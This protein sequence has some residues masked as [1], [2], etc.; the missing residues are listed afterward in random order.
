[1]SLLKWTESAT[2]DQAPNIRVVFLDALRGF[3]LLGIY[4][5]NIRVFAE[6]ANT[7]Y[8]LH[9]GIQPFLSD[10]LSSRFT[11]DIIEGTMRGLF[12]LLFGA[13]AMVFLNEARLASQ[14]LDIVDRYY[15]RALLLI[16]FGL[17]HAYLLLWPYDVL[18]IYGVISML[19]FP[20]RKISPPVL[21]VIGLL[22]LVIGD[23]D[24]SEKIEHLTGAG[25][26][27]TQSLKGIIE[28]TNKELMLSEDTYLQE[29]DIPEQSI[30][31][32]VE[33]SELPGYLTL[34]QRNI[35]NV[36]SQQ[37]SELY[38]D[39][40]FDVGGMMIIGIALFKLGIL[41][42]DRS[43]KFY[44]FMMIIC[45][46]L[47]FLA[48]DTSIYSHIYSFMNLG[49][50][51]NKSLAGYN[52]GRMI[53]T[54]GHIGLIGLLINLRIFSVI[55]RILVALGRLALTNYI[56]QTVI[57]LLIFYGFS[58]M[59]FEQFTFIQIIYILLIAWLFQ[60]VFSLIWLHYFKLGPME[61]VWRSLIY[62]KLQPIRKPV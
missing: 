59:L 43:R 13:S 50:S 32:P 4:W 29:I 61:W 28:S 22:L 31:D 2:P 55:I 10:I 1:M 30:T 18:Y 42:G 16:L 38:S 23:I 12:S 48:R 8:N 47:G 52:I 3:A 26:E 56:M 33:T 21:L 14:G 44:L 41:F 20:I 45:Y 49:D 24:L 51:L 40:I 34:F 17:L 57:S 37:S 35:S 19:L 11:S 53:V 36:V 25:K 60:I 46:G 6:D 5:I 7:F 58:E 15:R 62:G 9:I 54:L 27:Q 39:Y